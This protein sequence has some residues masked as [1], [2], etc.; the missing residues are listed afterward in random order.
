MPVAGDDQLN[1]VIGDRPR[2]HYAYDAAGNVT[3]DG[4]N[5]FLIDMTGRLRDASGAWGYTMS[6]VDG[7]GRRVQ[8]M[9]YIPNPIPYR[10]GTYVEIFFAYD[11]AG[12]LIG[13][14][15][16]NGQALQETVWLGDTPV[17]VLKAGVLYYVHAD[18]LDAPRVITDT[19]NRVVWRWDNAD[20]FGVGLPNEN[21]SGLGTFTYPL[22]FPGQ[23]YDQ[24][25]GLHYNIHRYYDPRTG[26]YTSFDPIGLAGGINGYGYANQNP[27]TYTDPLGLYVCYYSIDFHQMV[28]YSDQ[29]PSSPSYDSENWGSGSGNCYNNAACYTQ[30]N[31][32]PLPPGCYRV[33]G[34]PK[35][36]RKTNLNRR[37]LIP[38]QSI[39]SGR[40][41]GFQLHNCGNNSK[42]PSSKCSE[43]CAV[44]GRNP[45]RDFYEMLDEEPGSVICVN[46]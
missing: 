18:H 9:R 1:S 29:N 11:D 16:A 45:L 13:E 31:K 17:A 37:D 35:A 42:G 15:D 36:P 30:R 3:G 34:S 5:Q 28:C 25:T 32:G 19:Q 6:R 22:R 40:D 46:P 24:E 8:K 20:P 26:R 39:P 38:L 12:H 23:Y 21:P 44:T 14:Y 27:L 10:E 33:G 2:F 41:G 4:V 43:G 7:L